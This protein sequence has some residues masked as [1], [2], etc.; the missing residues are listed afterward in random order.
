MVS[1]RSTFVP[2][3]KKTKTKK[4][5]HTCL[6]FFSLVSDVLL[7]KLKSKQIKEFAF[8]RNFNKSIEKR[9]GRKHV[10]LQNQTNVEVTEKSELQWISQ[11]STDVFA[12]TGLLHPPAPRWTSPL[13][14]ASA[15]GMAGEGRA[16]LTQITQLK[17]LCYVWCLHWQFFPEGNSCSISCRKK[18]LFIQFKLEEGEPQQ[19]QTR[20]VIYLG[21]KHHFIML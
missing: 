21:R 2:L 18:W 4:S 13:A 14:L 12:V 15:G 5:N 3:V 6:G 7:C 1:H 17:R 16:V 19:T 10:S 9:E 11:S 8:K 20:R